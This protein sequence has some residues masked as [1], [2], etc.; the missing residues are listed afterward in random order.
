[1]IVQMSSDVAWPADTRILS[2][3]AALDVADLVGDR[4][5]LVQAWIDAA[6]TR[7]RERRMALAS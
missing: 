4:V 1:M 7:W 5:E 3:L 6:G 2:R